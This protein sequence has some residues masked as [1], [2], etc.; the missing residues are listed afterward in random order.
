[1]SEVSLMHWEEFVEGFVEQV[2][3]LAWNGRVVIDDG[4]NDSNDD[5]LAS[6]H[7]WNQMKV[8]TVY[9]EAVEWISP[10]EKKYKKWKFL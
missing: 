8:E 4:C 5:K 6:W 9:Q 2:S 1:M 10:K 7:V 3:S